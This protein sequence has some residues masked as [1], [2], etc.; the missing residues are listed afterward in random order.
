MPLHS[1]FGGGGVGGGF[2]EAEARA[3]RML[4]PYKPL[5]IKAISPRFRPVAR[6]DG[7]GLPVS[8]QD[9]IDYVKERHDSNN[10]P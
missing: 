7:R 4:P 5:D 6:N 1:G 8:T 10:L 3:P 2:N 9:R